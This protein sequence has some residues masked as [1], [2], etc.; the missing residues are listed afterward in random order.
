MTSVYK[1]FPFYQL[2]SVISYAMYKVS[3]NKKC[4]INILYASLLLNIFYVQDL[5]AF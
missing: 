4:P 5:F 3:Y 1:M 2:S